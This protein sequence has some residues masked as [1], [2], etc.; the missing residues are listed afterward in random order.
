VSPKIIDEV[1]FLNTPII[2]GGGIRSIEQIN[3][4]KDIGVNIIVIGNHIEENIDFLLDIHSYNLTK[5]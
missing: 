3:A 5:N 1:K 4:L 2:V